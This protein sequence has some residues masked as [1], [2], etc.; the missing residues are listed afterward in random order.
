MRRI[1]KILFYCLSGLASTAQP[2]AKKY[3][4]P[5]FVRLNDTVFISTTETSIRDYAYFMTIWRAESGD[6][7]LMQ[8]AFPVPNYLGWSY[9]DPF[10]KSF[11]IY[12]DQYEIGREDGL[13]DPSTDSLISFTS[14]IGNWPVVNVTK[15]Q[16]GLY[17]RF[18]TAYYQVFYNE[19]KERIKKKHPSRLFFRLPT[20]GEWLL[21]AAAGLDTAIYRHGVIDNNPSNVLLICKDIF[22]GEKEGERCP[23]PVGKGQISKNGLMNMCGNVAELVA[24]NDFVYGGSFADP[25]SDCTV[26]SRQLFTG[27]KNSI[28]F[29]IVAVI[30]E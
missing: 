7:D 8:K 29:R 2:V 16:A 15:E 23:V 26:G 6:P 17:C 30:R 24:D 25:A 4:L 5:G 10:S 11:I 1:I 3:S 19:Q 9:R 28:G 20:A 27:T 12:T 21:A 14:W 13:E 18:R 22:T